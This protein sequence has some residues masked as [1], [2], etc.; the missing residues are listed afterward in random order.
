MSS[1]D[2]KTRQKSSS[3][4]GGD[5]SGGDG[6]GFVMAVI[7]VATA[8]NWTGCRESEEER[9]FRRQWNQDNPD[10]WVEPPLL[11]RLIYGFSD[12]LGGKSERDMKPHEKAE[13]QARDAKE[14]EENRAKEKEEFEKWRDRNVPV[15]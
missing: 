1:I 3:S 8:M 6:C 4:S 10:S 7:L 11:S 13:K 9:E 2:E 15:P 12:V 5:G 14:L